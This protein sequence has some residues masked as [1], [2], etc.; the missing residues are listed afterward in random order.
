M[1]SKF[2]RINTSEVESSKVGKEVL[3]KRSEDFGRFAMV[4]IVQMEVY[5]IQDVP[6]SL[7]E[8][9]TVDSV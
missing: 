4:N 5:S 9:L 7:A 8:I 2:P 6:L 3:I 1:G